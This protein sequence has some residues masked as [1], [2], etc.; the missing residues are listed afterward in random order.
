MN[1]LKTL[2]ALL[3][4]AALLSG[5]GLIGQSKKAEPAAAA[6]AAGEK[7]NDNGFKKYSE[8]ITDD[9]G[10]L[11]YQFAVGEAVALECGPGNLPEMLVETVHACQL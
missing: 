1:L 8:V 6:Q 5:C 4:V 2:T 7:K 3:T 11:R 10:P 9:R